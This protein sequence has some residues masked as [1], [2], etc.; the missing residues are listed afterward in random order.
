VS[1]GTATIAPTAQA[2]TALEDALRALAKA[3]RAFQLYLPNNPTRAQAVE[4][5]RAAFTKV[6][7]AVPAVVLDIR[8][9]SFVWDERVVYQDLER[10][11]D[12]LPWLLYRDGLRA[13][14][15]QAG[16]EALELEVLLQVFHRARTAAA[17]EDDLVTLLWVADLQG[18]EY[19]HVELDGVVDLAV[20]SQDRSGGPGTDA[21]GREHAP[22]AVPAAESGAPG[23]GPPAG[24]V[25][26]EDF[27][28]TLYFLEPREVSYL[29]DELKRE[30]TDDQRRNALSMLF[31]LVE[32]PD[33]GDAPEQALGFIDQLL[34]ESLTM[35]DYEQ[36]AY[37]LREASAT[38]RRGEHAERVA[39]GLRELPAR[40]SD[41]AVM[42]QLLQALDEGARAPV[43]SLLENLFAE[44]RPAA[45]APLV[46][47]LGQATASPARASIE[48]ASLRLAGAHTG[49]LTALLEH[50][51][52]IIVRGALRV[53]A[54][55]ATPAA[56]PGLS[57][58]LRGED[59]G[60]RM[61]A[62]AALAEI[63]SPGALQALE[64]GVDDTHRDVRVATFRAIATRRHS[65]AMPRLA[66]VLRRKELRTADLGEK[67]AVFEAFGTVCG[68]A[69]VGELDTIL[70]ARGL[71]GAKENPEM[72][73]C[74]ARA[75]GLVGS[76]SAIDVLQRAADTK[77]VV[78][79]SAVARAMRGGA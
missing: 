28:S 19:R 39:N 31:D 24:F 76:A 10:G 79:R 32:L 44:L 66:Q 35:G 51:D 72:R 4:Q 25:R 56:V 55:L 69:G 7:G 60:L 42:G 75:L 78:V 41:P 5:A 48:R 8:E 23:D 17:D 18:V 70:N 38:L 30:Y 14:T 58:V 22:L 68:D 15:L 34:L 47:W 27:E 33:S 9:S 12:G 16:F 57:R 26:M 29:Q 67:M 63:A 21:S 40:L 53:A 77:D 62:I 59:E 46:M 54:L 36:V 20:A 73:A 43:P 50:A 2:T 61:E 37:V 3:Q 49:E 11:T 65:G 64:R 45:L 13:L 74:A 1:V 71:L 52:P 6:W